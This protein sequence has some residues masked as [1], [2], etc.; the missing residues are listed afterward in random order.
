MALVEQTAPSVEPLSASEAKS[1]IRVD[2]SDDDTLIGTYIKAARQDRENFTRRAFVSQTWD[3]YLDA[4]PGSSVI[5]LPKPPLQS[6]THIKY[7]DEDG[8]ETEFSSDSYQVDIYSE[9]GR[10]MLKSGYSWPS[11]TLQV[12]NGVQIRFVCGYG[13][14]GSDVPENFRRAIA[15]IVGSLYENREDISV[16]QLF[17]IPRGADLL[18]WPNRFW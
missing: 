8:N 4:F 13:D 16:A 6:V 17:S 3:L 10:I 5:E 7:T 12:M 11:D 18:C 9:P 14:A 1:H 15:L 2:I